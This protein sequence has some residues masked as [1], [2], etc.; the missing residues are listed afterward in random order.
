MRENREGEKKK[1]Q[2]T[3]TTSTN[4]KSTGVRKTSE[5]YLIYQ[6]T[7]EINQ[8]YDTIYNGYVRNGI[9]VI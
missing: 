4:V 3:H 8:I 6:Q 9:N 5:K 2:Q 1:K 7:S